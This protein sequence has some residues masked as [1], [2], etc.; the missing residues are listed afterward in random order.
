MKDNLTHAV[1]VIH[2]LRCNDWKSCH[3]VRIDDEW[4]SIV[5]GI[6]SKKDSQMRGVYKEDVHG[7]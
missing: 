2:E 4:R 7:S 1:F 3:H 5:T 6:L